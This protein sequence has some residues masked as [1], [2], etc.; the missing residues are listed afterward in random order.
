MRF[1]EIIIAGLSVA[2][3]QSIAV[4]GLPAAG[5]LFAR[6]DHPPESPCLHPGG[7]RQCQIYCASK[8]ADF[9]SCAPTCVCH[10]ISTTAPPTATPTGPPAQTSDQ[11]T[12]VPTPSG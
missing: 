6:Q 12:A 5:L 7:K 1:S 11:P 8:N 9:Y 4:P 3:V 10:F 2:A